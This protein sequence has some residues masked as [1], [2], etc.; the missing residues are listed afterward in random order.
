MR[1]RSLYR[2]K[3]M[4]ISI[5]LASLLFTACSYM[6]SI[7]HLSPYKM[8]IRQGNYITPDMR[9]KIKIGMTRQQVRYVLGTPLLNDSFHANRW[10]YIY[11]LIKEE[12]LVEQHRLTLV[13]EGENLIKIEEDNPAT[14]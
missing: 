10:D 7:P 6:P 14:K 9:E 1:R 8:D 11:R 5:I 12:K 3:T 2:E 13:F 4:R